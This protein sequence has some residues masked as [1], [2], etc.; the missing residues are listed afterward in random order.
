MTPALAAQSSGERCLL[1]GAR[2]HPASTTG[3]Q[4]VTGNTAAGA[5][6]AVR[7]RARR[8]AGASRRPDAQRQFEGE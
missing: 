4:L 8:Y 2:V 1:Y 6:R 5:A 3:C 7:V